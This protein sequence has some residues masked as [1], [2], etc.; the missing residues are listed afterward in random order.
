MNGK[1]M[2]H[3]VIEAICTRGQACLLSHA[4]ELI[5]FTSYRVCAGEAVSFTAMVVDADGQVREWSLKLDAEKMYQR[6]RNIA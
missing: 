5:I 1:E 3:A 4:G 6:F 2:I